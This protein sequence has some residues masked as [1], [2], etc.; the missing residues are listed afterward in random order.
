MLQQML[1]NQRNS[2]KVKNIL[3]GSNLTLHHKNISVKMQ[4]MGDYCRTLII[5]LVYNMLMDMCFR[6]SNKTTVVCHWLSFFHLHSLNLPLGN[7]ETKANLSP[8]DTVETVLK[9]ELFSLL[10]VTYNQRNQNF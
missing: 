1:A 2:S 4:Y 5:L 8:R 3:S 7:L 9:A 6:K 10:L